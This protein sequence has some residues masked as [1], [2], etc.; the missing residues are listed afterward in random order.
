MEKEVGN[1]RFAFE[2][3]Q[4]WRGH[5]QSEGFVVIANYIPKAD[6]DRYVQDFWGVMEVLSDGSLDRNDPNTHVLSKSYPP[7]MHGGMIQYIGHSK[8][9]WEL[10]KRAVPLFAKLWKTNKLRTSFD[11][12]CFMNGE[13]NYQN[14]PINSFLHCDQAPIHRDVWSFQGVQ[15][16]SNSGEDEGGFV[17]CPK[18]NLIHQKWFREHGMENSKTNWYK[19]T[20][21]E[22][23]EEALAHCIKVNSQASDFILFDSRTFH[24]NTI[25]T[26]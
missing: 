6:C 22:K 21:D 1:Y 9:Q 12:F 4:A 7:V 23:K 2:D 5:L 20:E 3:E 18:T 14:R 16:L 10:R 17:C 24:C 25:P 8:P 13:R 19:F 11:G 15:T 26:K